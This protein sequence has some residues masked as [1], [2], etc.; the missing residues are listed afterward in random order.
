[1]STEG[2]LFRALERGHSIGCETIQLFSKN[3]SR[4]AAKELTD[5]EIEEFKTARAQTGIDPVFAH[6][7][8]LINL[9][10]PNHFYKMSIQAL[11]TEIQRGEQLG[12]DF[13][14]LH[15][16]AHMGKGDGEGLKRIVAALDE[17][18]ERT[19]GAKCGVA[20]ENTAGQGSCVG[21]TF[22]HL[23]YL[24]THVRYPECLSFCIDTCH[25]FASGYDIRTKDQYDSTLRRLLDH[26]PLEKIR[27]FHLNDSK[28][29]IG[30][31]VDRSGA[32]SSG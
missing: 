19:S 26:V 27:A 23:E 1:M 8:Y 18:M 3:S 25:L 28:K 24:L 4:W 17:G 7:S 20:I 2:G 10:A 16:G 21:C 11:I 31:R 14:V 15:P 32:G 29:D 22:E 6:C 5:S 9:A 12:L 13:V 30:S